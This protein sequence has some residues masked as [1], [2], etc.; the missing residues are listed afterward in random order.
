MSSPSVSRLTVGTVCDAVSAAV[1][2]VLSH[3]DGRLPSVRLLQTEDLRH[4]VVCGGMQQDPARG[5]ADHHVAA[6]R[7]QADRNGIWTC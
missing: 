2:V 1:L 3:P 7:R 6:H 5:Q 4:H